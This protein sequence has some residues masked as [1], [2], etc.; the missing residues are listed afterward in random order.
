MT[1][2]KNSFFI[3]L[4]AIR[5]FTDTFSNGLVIVIVRGK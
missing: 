5:S 1:V 2:L 3:D 4:R